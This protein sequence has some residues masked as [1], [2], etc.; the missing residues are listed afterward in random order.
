M[1]LLQP[2]NVSLGFFKADAEQYKKEKPYV[3]LVPLTHAPPGFSQSNVEYH[4]KDV[5]VYNIRGAE[6]QFKL[7]VHGFQLIKHQ[8]RFDAWQDGKRV[9]KEYNPHV[10][11]LLKTNLGVKYVHIYDHTVSLF[12]PYKLNERPTDGV[13]TRLGDHIDTPQ[14]NRN[15]QGAPSISAHVGMSETNLIPLQY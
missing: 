2:H 9:V 7:D 5:N 15:V 8:P 3:C 4:D 13:E 11:E 14:R 10:I 1:A 6:D 12:I